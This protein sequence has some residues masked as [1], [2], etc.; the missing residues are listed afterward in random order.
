MTTD[1]KRYIAEVPDFPKKGILFRDISPLLNTPHA[2]KAAVEGMAEAVRRSGAQV[3][4]AIESRGF[5]F[6]AP[7]AVELGIPMVLVRKP[8][9]LPGER[10]QISYGLEYGKDTL[11]IKR[12]M[13]PEGAS[14][15]IVDD[16]LATGGTAVAT[17]DLVTRAG[18]NV[19]SY[20]FLLE[21]LGLDGRGRLRGVPAVSLIQY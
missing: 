19:V 15:A 5:I 2:F 8:G 14:V 1:L 18:G 10:E 11:E 6:G 16:V 12:G 7:I 21:L 4:V 20:I 13:I 9:K 17:A 3:I